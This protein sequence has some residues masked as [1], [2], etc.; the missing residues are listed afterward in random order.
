MEWRFMPSSYPSFLSLEN[1]E[2]EKKMTILIH[3]PSALAPEMCEL[4]FPPKQ[5]FSVFLLFVCLFDWLVD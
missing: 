4:A 1:S 3:I 5:P 2:E